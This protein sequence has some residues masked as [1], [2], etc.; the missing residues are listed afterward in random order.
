MLRHYCQKIIALAS[1]LIAAQPVF[2][3]APSSQ[4]MPSILGAWENPHKSVRVETQL[5]GEQLCGWVIWATPESIQDAHDGGTVKL[6]GTKLL[7]NYRQVSPD[8]WQGQVFL[9][10]RGSHFYSTIKPMDSNNIKI[11]GCILGGWICKSQIWH[12]T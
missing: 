11:S 2:A 10:D 1:L 3:A 8:K 12:R 6:I 7:E 4:S 5:C 9:P